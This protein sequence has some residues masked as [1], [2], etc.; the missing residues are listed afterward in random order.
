MTDIDKLAAL[1]VEHIREA[2]LSIE[3]EDDCKRLAGYL[4][5]HGVV[6]LDTIEPSEAAIDALF[7]ATVHVWD[8]LSVNLA[9]AREPLRRALR[10]AYRAQDSK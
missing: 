2:W 1:I 5:E 4:I 6:V 3:D 10:D 7:N 9:A 8:R